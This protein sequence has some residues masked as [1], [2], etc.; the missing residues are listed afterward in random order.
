MLDKKTDVSLDEKGS[1]EKMAVPEDWKNKGMET[2]VKVALGMDVFFLPDKAVGVGDHWEHAVKGKN[3]TLIASS[4][5]LTYTLR[6]VETIHGRKQ[7]VVDFESSLEKANDNPGK[8]FNLTKY[9]ESL[10]GT[11]K[12]DVATGRV[13]ECHTTAQTNIELTEKENKMTVKRS[14]VIDVSS[15]EGKYQAP[16]TKP[17]K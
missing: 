15:K 12:V 17:A 1:I 4:L 3:P 14:N 13:V 7:A 8:Q 5:K 16:A 6:E 11:A 2:S 10:K 9:E